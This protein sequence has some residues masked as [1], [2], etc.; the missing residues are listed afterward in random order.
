M[1]TLLSIVML[2]LIIAACPSCSKEIAGFKEEI[3]ILKEENNF[4]KAESIALR[5][6]LEELYKRIE[7][8]DI[9]SSKA[10]MKEKEGNQ[11]KESIVKKPEKS[12]VEKIKK[13]E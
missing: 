5:K 11:A 4:L 8:K 6:E 3:K 12:T 10:I 9:T 13:P 1:K 2:L 7:E